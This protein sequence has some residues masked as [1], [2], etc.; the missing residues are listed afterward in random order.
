MRTGDRRLL[1]VRVRLLRRVSHDAALAVAL[2]PSD[3]VSHALADSVALS[4]PDHAGPDALADN[5]RPDLDALPLDDARARAHGPAQH[6]TDAPALG[7]SGATADRPALAPPESPTD[8]DAHGNAHG[9]TRAVA[10]SGAFSLAQCRADLGAQCR[11]HRE[12]DSDPDDVT[13]GIA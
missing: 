12:A 7:R 1:R 5:S 6:P 10:D 11:A 8:L 2:A 9:A 3:A 4:V 13:D